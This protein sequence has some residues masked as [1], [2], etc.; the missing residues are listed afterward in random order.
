MNMAAVHEFEFH[1]V[2]LNSV[3]FPTITASCYLL[4]VFVIRKVIVSSSSRWALNTQSVQTY[5]NLFLS[6]LS[7]VMLFGC[8]S[9]LIPRVTAEGPLF[10]FCESSQPPASGPLYFWSYIYML[11]KIYELLDTFLQLLKGRDPPSF[12]LHVGH[13]AAVLLMA[14]A[15]LE[16]KQSLQFIGLCFNCLVHV[17]MYFYYFLLSATGKKPWWK[18]L[19]TTVQIVQF[20]TSPAFFCVTAYLVLGEGRDCAGWTPLLGNLFFNVVLLSQF[21]GILVGGGGKKNQKKQ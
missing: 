13:H 8:L 7:L 5:H 16:Y 1:S 9:E 17:I 14:W 15:W 19:V 10:L 3:Y 6:V 21:V 20:A 18:Q 12:F 4:A 11:S 2:P